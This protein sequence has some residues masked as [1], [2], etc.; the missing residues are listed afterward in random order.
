MPFFLDAGDEGRVDR[1]DAAS[2]F[3]AHLQM[4]TER[5]KANLARAL[6]DELG[7]IIVAAIIICVALRPYHTDGSY[8]PAVDQKFFVGFMPA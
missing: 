3:I 4:S 5:D 1:A 8:R 2:A 7:A 6:H